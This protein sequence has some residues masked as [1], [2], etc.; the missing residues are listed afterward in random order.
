MGV[1]DLR[2]A[3]EEHSEAIAAEYEEWDANRNGAIPLYLDALNS[4]LRDRTDLFEF[5][6]R[7]DSLSKSEAHWGFRGTSQMFFNQ[8]V[9]AGDAAELSAALRSTLGAPEDEGDA[10]HRIGVLEEAVE[11]TRARAE[12]SGATKPGIGRIN[13]FVSFFWEL[14]DRKRWPMFYPNSRD[15]L[16]QQE[17]LDLNQGQADLYLA[18]RDVVFELRHLLETDTWGVEHLLWRLG[19]GGEEQRQAV[20]ESNFEEAAPDLYARYREQGLHFPDETVTSLV[21]SLATKRFVILSGISGTGKTKIALGLAHYLESMAEGSE[22]EAEPPESGPKEIYIR[23]TAPKLQRGYVSLVAEARDYF[24]NVLELPRRGSSRTYET[25]L[26]DGSAHRTRLNNVGFRDESRQLFRLYLLKDIAAWLEGSAK[27]GDYL[28]LALAPRPGVDLALSIVRGAKTAD[29]KAPKRHVT[30]AVRSDW[31]DPRGL[32]GYFNPI[33]RSYVQTDLIELLLRAAEDP[34]SPYL[35]VLDEMNLARVEFYFSDFLSALESGE[36]LRLMAPGLE[37][38]SAAAAAESGEPEV[39]GS[40]PIPP[41]VSFVGTVNVDETTHSFSPKVLDRANVIEFG[42]VDVERALGH[43]VEKADG[44]LRLRDGAFSPGWL[45][46]TRD[47]AMR[48]KSRAHEIDDFTGA[49]EDVHAIL[50]EFGLPF[51]YRVIDEVSAFVG[52]A[53]EKAEGGQEEIVRQT[54]DLQ[55][56]QKIVVKLSG[57]RELEAPVAN[58]LDYCLDGEKRSNVDVTEVREDAQRRLRP[59]EDQGP[60]RYPRSARRL[61][62]MLNRLAAT[63]FVGALE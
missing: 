25:E 16:E 7:I 15:V 22:V 36:D 54:F 46:T 11:A 31:T 27:P 10:R 40:L 50:S 26:P 6:S 14:Q 45:C 49:L 37:E 35:L 23:L 47:E 12:A 32:I 53:L 62:R 60:V 29:A 21:L 59:A 58:L 57:G 56:Q 28:R 55:L 43:G 13:S 3:W 19:K 5:R 4:F 34:E 38:E 2:E 8:L 52:H 39:P 48:T 41:N 44:G 61:L 18:Y 42:E 30:I 51:G 1:A 20:E 63:G 24:A 9:K 17:M 33:T